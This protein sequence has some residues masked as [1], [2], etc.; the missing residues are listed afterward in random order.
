MPDVILLIGTDASGKD[1]IAGVLEKMIEEGGGCVEK[2]KRSFSGPVTQETSSANKG[3][4]DRIQESLFLTLYPL[5]GR[6]LPWLFCA[7]TRLDLM[8]FRPPHKKLIVVGHNGLRA[9]AFHWARH[10]SKTGGLPPVSS[11]AYRSF[12]RLRQQTGAHA[13]VL[14]VD[15]AVRH[16]RIQERVAK[17]VADRFDLHML[18][19]PSFSEHVE[20]SLVKGAQGLLNAELIINNDLKEDAIRA[21]I[22]QMFERAGQAFP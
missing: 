1:H 19:N 16:K 8:M 21:R 2:R 18:E 5:C 6:A 13:I 4:A 14:D 15:H 9:M 12:A 10:A 3:L 22:R 7:W 11:S 20:A 17:D